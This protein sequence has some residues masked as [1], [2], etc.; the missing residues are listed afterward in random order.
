MTFSLFGFEVSMMEL[1]ML[2]FF[3]KNGVIRLLWIIRLASGDSRGNIAWFCRFQRLS[4]EMGF[5]VHE[6]IWTHSIP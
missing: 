6:H 5:I 4:M 3:W 1:G 2:D